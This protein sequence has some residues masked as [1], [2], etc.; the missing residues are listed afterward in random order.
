MSE[1][2]ALSNLEPVTIFVEEEEE[3][4]T[5]TAATTTTTAPE[6]GEAAAA[7]A[8]IDTS[9]FTDEDWNKIYTDENLYKHPKF[10]KLRADAK[11]AK[12]LETAQATA[13]QE[14]LK[15]QGKWKEIAEQH[16]GKIKTLTEQFQQTALDNAII[17][18]AAT[19]GVKDLE[20][21]KK[22]LDRTNIKINDDGSVTGVNEAIQS[23]VKQYPTIIQVSTT[24]VGSGA[25]PGAEETT[26]KKFKA[27]DFQNPE[28]FRKNEK[29]MMEAW[30]SNNVD[31]QN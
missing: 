25:S 10:A 19:A 14:R 16:E 18:A 1:S 7:A 11:K 21:A 15:E 5:S 17:A 4:E 27:S 28:F 29:D 24:T 30:R 20:V 3:E 9:K 22:L 6:G 12:D 2:I 31:M 26:P 13:E 8:G 23:L